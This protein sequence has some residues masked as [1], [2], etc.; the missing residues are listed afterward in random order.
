[1]E[2]EMRRR[3]AHEK[4]TRQ[5]YDIIESTEKSLTYSDKPY[6]EDRNENA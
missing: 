6:T 5:R 4:A 3:M 2:S 1:M